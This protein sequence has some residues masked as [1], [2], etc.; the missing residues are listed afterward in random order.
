MSR[1]AASMKVSRRTACSTRLMGRAM[2]WSTNTQ[3]DCRSKNTSILARQDD[4]AVRP[5]RDEPALLA[6]VEGLAIGVEVIR[7]MA[8]EDARVAGGVGVEPHV[9]ATGCR[10]PDPEIVDG[11]VGEVRDDDRVVVRTAGIPTVHD[12]DLGLLVR[13]QDRDIRTAETGGRAVHRATQRDEVAMQADDAAVLA[14]LLPVDP[15]RVVEPAV[16]QML[17]ALEQHRDPRRGEDERGPEHG[18][19]LRPPAARVAG[20]DGLWQADQAVG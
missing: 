13:P 12:E 7:L 20:C 18:P 4:H 14:R 2:R 6:A 10:E 17:L 16:L 8:A 1:R 5:D 11:A 9:P 19:L 3:T 15:D